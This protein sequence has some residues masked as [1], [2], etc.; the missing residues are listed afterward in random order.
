MNK[1]EQRAAD[2]WEQAPKTSAPCSRWLGLERARCGQ[3]PTVEMAGISRAS[4]GQT[5]HRCLAHAIAGRGVWR[6]RE[7]TKA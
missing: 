5:T 3:K 2:E 7:R 6:P 4:L 1:H